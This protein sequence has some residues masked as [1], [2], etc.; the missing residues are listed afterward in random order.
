MAKALFLVLAL[1]LF[2]AVTGQGKV[3]GMVAGQMTPSGMFR[4]AVQLLHV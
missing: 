4:R 2:M 1:G 3:V